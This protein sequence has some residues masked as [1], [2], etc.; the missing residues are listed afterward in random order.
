MCCWG[1]A[2]A[3]VRWQRTTSASLQIFSL[4]LYHSHTHFQVYALCNILSKNLPSSRQACYLTSTSIAKQ[5]AIPISTSPDEDG[6]MRASL[7][8]CQRLTKSWLP[9][10]LPACLAWHILAIRLNEQGLTFASSRI[11]CCLLGDTR[12]EGPSPALEVLVH[13][14][15]GHL[16]G[17]SSCVQRRRLLEVCSAAVG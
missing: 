8:N 7:L 10:R 12:R 6:R 15:G 13:E 14:G 17:A 11:A 1:A 5:N 3:A 4:T 9:H 2:R 16:Q